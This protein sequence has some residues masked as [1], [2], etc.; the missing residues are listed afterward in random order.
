[1]KER[2]LFLAVVTALTAACGPAQP[3]PDAA[4]DSAT[5]IASMDAALDSRPTD[6]GPLPNLYPVI[7]NPQLQFRTVAANDC[8]VEE[9]CTMPG[10]R[11]LLRFDLI[12]PNVGEADLHLGAPTAANRPREMFEWGTCHNHWHLRDY[13]DYR[14]YDLAGN[15]VGRGHKQS[16]CLEDFGSWMGMGAPNC[17]NPP[18][19]PDDPP[20]CIH[21]YTCENQGIHRGNHDIYDR[22]LDCQYV[23]VTGVPPGT[24]RLVVRINTSRVVQESNYEDN[25]AE[26][27]VTITEPGDAAP[28]TDPTQACTSREEGPDRECGW[29]AE[30]SPRRC[31]PGQMVEVGCNAEC[32]PPLGRCEGDTMI[33]ICAGSRPC[34]HTDASGRTPPEFIAQNDDACGTDNTCSYVRFT[35]PAGGEYLI[36]TGSYR[37][38]SP[39]NCHIAVRP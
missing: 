2:R 38:G 23:D 37:A 20:G 15:E 1:M 14:L 4:H 16:F 10:F 6:A 33:R 7:R 31:T 29:V 13:A 22:S 26:M 8:E 9:G 39:S 36:M 32:S 25:V 18:G 28:P 24:Y 34:M 30:M 5:D 19:Q 21:P 35:C 3:R 12:T 11:R 27:M 17:R